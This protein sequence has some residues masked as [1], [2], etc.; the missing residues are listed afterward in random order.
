M[1]VAGWCRLGREGED[2]LVSPGLRSV[3]V[4]SASI[5]GKVVCTCGNGALEGSKPGSQERLRFSSWRERRKAS[6]KGSP[7]AANGYESS[8]PTYSA[9]TDAFKL[10]P[11]ERQEKC[12][13]DKTNTTPRRKLPHTKLPIL[14]GTP[15]A[16]VGHQD[17]RHQGDYSPSLW[18]AAFM[19]GRMAAN[20]HRQNGQSAALEPP[21]PCLYPQPPFFL[22]H[23]GSQ[24]TSS[25]AVSDSGEAV[26]S[27][28]PVA[29][30]R[31]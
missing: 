28:E 22:F 13:A 18:L 10:F 19:Q 20:K 2:S 15:T 26:L 5:W 31:G 16:F 3:C 9:E 30:A 27:A 8:N 4:V 17:S 1:S 21:L 23:S 24:D 7:A 29:A 6:S 25:T 14:A 11:I 12:S